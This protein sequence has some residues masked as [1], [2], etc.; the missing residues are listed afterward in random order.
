MGAGGKPN[1]ETVSAMSDLRKNLYECPE[2]SYRVR[3]WE[4]E[5]ICPLCGDGRQVLMVHLPQ[6]PRS[7]QANANHRYPILQRRRG[8]MGQ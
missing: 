8:Q 1:E 5:K 4:P 2:C 6:Q 3:S 7:P